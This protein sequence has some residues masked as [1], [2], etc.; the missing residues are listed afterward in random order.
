MLTRVQ[1][2]QAQSGEEPTGGSL[3][4]GQGGVHRCQSFVS[5]CVRGAPG[6]AMKDGVQDGL[7]AAHHPPLTVGSPCLPGSGMQDGLGAAHHPPL[8]VGSPFLPGSGMQ[9]GLGAAHHPPLTVGSPC[10]PG[11]GMQH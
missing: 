5:L 11:S 2:R 1:D 8:T 7:G 4:R 3:V 9:D 10:L 6:R